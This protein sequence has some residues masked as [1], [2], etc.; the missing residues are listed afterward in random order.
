[1]QDVEIHFALYKIVQ[2]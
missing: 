2:G 1:M